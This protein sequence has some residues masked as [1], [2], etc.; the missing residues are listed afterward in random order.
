MTHPI[1]NIA[2]LKIQSVG[3]ERAPKGK[4]AGNYDI[5][6]GE[7]ASRIGARKRPS[8]GD[9]WRPALLGCA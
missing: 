5:R 3:P 4:N 7:I 6:W 8:P 9:G 1:I 2:D